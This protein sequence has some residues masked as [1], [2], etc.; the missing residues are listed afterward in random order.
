V[1]AL[2]K[3]RIT[4]FGRAL[5]LSFAL[6]AAFGS[7][8]TSASAS[9]ETDFMA[10]AQRI[11]TAAAP[12]YGESP[13]APM[14]DTR[15]V[16]NSFGPRPRT[17]RVAPGHSQAWFTR[18]NAQGLL[19]GKSAPQEWLIHE[20]AHVLQR[21]DLTSW[22]GEGGAQAFARYAAPRIYGSLGISFKQPW[23][24]AT[25][26]YLAYMNHVERVHGWGW[27]KY[28]QFSPILMAR[29]Q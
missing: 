2:R 10:K 13:E 6:C 26:D 25:D 17:V 27:I 7:A 15:V 23:S 20:W 5:L 19:N 28:G 11:W 21:S 22:E 12:Y 18:S 14:P 9:V 8:V 3:H 1:L 16:A 4:R 24:R 29:G